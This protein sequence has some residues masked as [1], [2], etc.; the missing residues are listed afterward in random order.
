MGILVMFVVVN[1]SSVNF[2][3]YF[4]NVIL[5][6]SS[7]LYVVTLRNRTPKSSIYWNK[8]IRHQDREK[9][10][11]SRSSS[12]TQITDTAINNEGT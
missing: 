3:V 5:I 4:T 2:S 11:E 7:S 8:G 9:N 1:K 12:N 6:A 10:S